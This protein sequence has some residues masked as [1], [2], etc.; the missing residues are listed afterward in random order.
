MSQW[1]DEI[2]EEKS[3]FGLKVKRTLFH[4]KSEFQTIDIIDTE[5]FGKVLALDGIF[6]TSVGDEYYYHEMLVHPA[7]TTTAQIKRVVVV[8]GGD[9][10]SV[11]E[12]LRYPE[13]ERVTM[14][15]IDGIV[16]DACKKHLPEIGQAW[17]DPRLQ[18]LIQD[19][20]A[21]VEKVEPE[22]VDVIIVDGPDPVGPAV[23]LFKKEFYQSC[24]ERL[25][26]QGVLAVQSESP[27]VMKEEFFQIVSELKKVFRNVH[28]YFGPVPIYPGSGWSYVYASNAQDPLKIIDQRIEQVEN[29]C[30]YYN[31]DIHRSAFAL[32]NEV[33]RSLGVE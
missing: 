21:Y 23:G 32:P 22:S 18:L 6:Q 30:R 25:T 3:R 33:K 26:K 11:R 2:F 31:R 17:E 12:I 15:E 1:Y 14:V 20:I 8:G 19:G 29:G 28:P 10:G 7:L 9:G 24:S 13:V 4:A 27:H 5:I 16:V